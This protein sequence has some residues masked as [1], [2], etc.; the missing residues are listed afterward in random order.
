[1]NLTLNPVSGPTASSVAS[2]A[3]SVTVPAGQRTITAPIAILSNPGAGNADVL[4]VGA[5]VVILGQSLSGSAAPPQLSISGSTPASS[6]N[7][8]GIIWK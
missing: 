7:S 1:V 2:I 6:P 3:S 8:G 4:S 5:Y